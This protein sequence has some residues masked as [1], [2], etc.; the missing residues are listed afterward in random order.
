MKTIKNKKSLQRLFFIILIIFFCFNISNIFFLVLCMKE[1]IFRPPHTEVLVSACKQPAAT[2]VPG[3][4]AVFVNEGLTDNFYLLD[5][6]TG[7]KRTVPNDPLLM[8]YGI[9]LNSELVWLEGSWGKPNNTAGYRPHYILDLKNGTRYEVMDLD[10]LA[11]DDDG[12][13]DP[14]NYTYL[15]SAEKIFIHHSKNILI[16]LSSDFRTSPDER[17]ALSQY[18]LKSGSDVENGKAL[19]KLLKDL[20]LSYEIIDITTTRYKDIPSPTGQFVIR[21]E[22]IYISGTNTS[23]V[24]RRYTGGYFMGGYFKNWFYDESAVVVQEDYSFLISNTLLGS[25]YSIPKPV[26]K[27]FLPVE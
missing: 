14:Q 23:M 11:R 13:F 16:A 6:Q 17:V 27:L 5:L 25:Y 8:D 20:G 18:V 19:E 3:G 22:G 1:D 10:W 24:D 26:L 7:E 9:F 15:Q 21:N 12:Y 4:D 2:G